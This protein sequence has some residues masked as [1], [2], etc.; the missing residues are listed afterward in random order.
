[1]T[2][3][4]G[5]KSLACV[6]M[7]LEDFYSE[8][9]SYA[10]RVKLHVRETRGELDTAAHT[11]EDL[12]KNAQVQAII[13]AIQ[14]SG[15]DELF[16]QLGS[17]YRIPV[18]SFSSVS[19]TWR[20]HTTP[21]LL[22][23]AV[24][25]SFQVAPITEIL[26][27][28]SWHELTIVCEDSPYETGIFQ[29]LS[30]ALQSNKVHSMDS[31]AMPIC[32]TNDQLDQVLNHLKEKPTR[33]FIV[34]LRPALAVHFFSRAK[35][36]GMITEDYLW[37]VSA[38]LGNVADSLSPNDID[39][40]QGVMTL[41]PYV[42]ATRYVY[43][44][45]ARFHLNNQDPD[46]IYN[47]S[48][49]FWAYD[50]AWATAMAVEIALLSSSA[51]LM[52][53]TDLG[54]NGLSA[55][56]RALLD[57]ILD[58]TFDGLAGRF[59]LVN[60]ERQLPP[61]EI[62][63][64]TGKGAVGAVKSEAKRRT[65]RKLAEENLGKV[66]GGLPK[67]NSSLPSTTEQ[68]TGCSIDFFKAALK[69]LQ[70]DPQ[71][72]EF[73]VFEGLYDE[74]VQDVS[75]GNLDGAVGDL[76]ITSERTRGVDFTMPYTQSGVYLLVLSE[77]DIESIQWIFIKP[78]TW[79]LWLATVVF[80]FFT[81]FVVWMI[82]RPRNPQYQ[83]SSLRQFITASYFAFST[84]TFSHDQIIRSPLSK[85]VVVI[86]CFVVLI[87]VQSYTASLSSMLTAERLRPSV[88][89]LDQL[90]NNGD[91]IGYQTGSFVKT[92]LT[93][94]GWNDSRLNN[95][96]TKAQYAEAL[97]KGSKNDGVS[98]IVE[99]IPFL[100]SF[101]SDP[102]YQKE[103]R[104]VKTIYKTPGFGFAFPLGFPLLH[105]LSTALLNVS[106]GDE[107]SKIEARWLGTDSLS[108]S[109]GRPNTDSTPLTL[110]SFSGLFITSGCISLAMMLIRIGKFLHA[111]WTQVKDSNVQNIGNNVIDE[112]SCPLQNSTSNVSVP[113]QP[114]HEAGNDVN[115]GAHGSGDSGGMVE[116]HPIQN[117]MGNSSAHDRLNEAIS[118]N[119]SRGV[120]RSSAGATYEEPSAMNNGF[121]P[122]QS[123]Q[124]EMNTV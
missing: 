84:L 18:L 118:N 117:D 17:H 50:T 19:P 22:H 108:S 36:A 42:Q 59:K 102:Q 58:T 49:L 53:N 52:N 100:T 88:T 51:L 121:V 68:I 119:D 46:D 62:V 120:Y 5:R 109:Y 8:H 35:Y 3:D 69:Q 98:A 73:C 70:L 10:T 111:K 27:S 47:P 33:L 66:C 76:T 86:W 115:Q 21:F 24:K 29:P 64:A 123:L 104:M 32:V 65:A 20:L 81:G 116:S 95:Y 16:S 37:I 38:A 75:L 74:L 6:S 89:D 79:E 67:S 15:E 48:V 30:D 92:I 26:T 87:L 110:Q 103:F 113:D 44:F 12:I 72:Y 63:I 34:H 80:F 96:S 11:A 14:T 124:I 105:N 71:C 43:N 93:S 40:L 31:V 77:D 85:I 45:S 1:M 106:G 114:H 82:E 112:E 55:S 101:L 9:P 57:S 91:N 83:G 13:V 4:M 107:G 54:R 41:R 39:Y 61:Y 25:D 97:R 78:L 28:F 122:A 90:R 94:Q 56:R 60:G 7:A 2:S 23:T 99:E